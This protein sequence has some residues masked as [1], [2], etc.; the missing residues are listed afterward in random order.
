MDPEPEPLT[1]ASL[2]SPWDALQAW[3]RGDVGASDVS[4][5]ADLSRADAELLA[6]R[7]PALGEET[8]IAVA[9]TMLELAEERFDLH[10]GRAL[11]L[12]LEDPS[13]TVRQLAVAALWEDEGADLPGRLLA[14]IAADPSQDVVAQA[15]QSLASTSERVAMSEIDP[16]QARHIAA[17]LLGTADDVSLA[18]TV[19]RRALEVGAVC[20]DVRRVTHLIEE[21]YEADE[22]GFRASAVYAM[23]RTAD[24]RWLPRI[25]SEFRDDDAELRFEAARAAGELGDSSVLPGLIELAADE[26][27]EVRQAAIGAIGHIGGRAGVRALELLAANAGESD[28]DAIEEARLEA[29]TSVDPLTVER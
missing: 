14:I 17:I 23:G 5:L 28:A 22:P 15:I 19:R 6:Q 18:P 11:R 13:A 26:D 9:R 8:R 20:G 21:F 25:L 2:P 12:M 16:D 29:E 4:A 7:W 24:R 3:Q 27:P 10:F 1:G